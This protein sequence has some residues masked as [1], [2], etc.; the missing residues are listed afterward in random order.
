[1]SKITISDVCN[2]LIAYS[3]GVLLVSPCVTPI[4][5]NSVDTKAVSIFDQNLNSIKKGFILADNMSLGKV[6][7]PSSSVPEIVGF[8]IYYYV[9]C[10]AGY[11]P[12]VLSTLLFKFILSEL[13]KS[14]KLD[15]REIKKMSPNTVIWKKGGIYKDYPTL[16]MPSLPKQDKQLVDI[17]D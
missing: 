3:F 7:H 11:I 17:A 13:S 2:S 10:T 9:A 14:N 8:I 5:R 4:V 15:L 1:M 16:Q 6:I 12:I